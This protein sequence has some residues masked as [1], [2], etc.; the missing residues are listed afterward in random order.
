M[1]EPFFLLGALTGEKGILVSQ[2]LSAVSLSEAYDTRWV[3]PSRICRGSRCDAKSHR[4]IIHVVHYDSL[5][6]RAVVRPPSHMSLDDVSAVQERHCTVG[7]NPH[8]VSCVGSED[9]ET[10]DVQT[11]LAALAKLA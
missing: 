2:V 5:M 8:L 10:G 4:R 11:K 9:W 7:P 6:F 1:P 3:Q